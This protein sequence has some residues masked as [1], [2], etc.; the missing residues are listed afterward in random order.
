VPKGYVIVTE[1][2][3]DP[4]GM[5]A[6]GKLSGASVVE[7]GATVLVVDDNVEVVE[8]EWHG[9]RTIVLEYDSVEKARQW[10]ESASY[11]AA[12]PLRQAAAEC[13]VVILSGFAPRTE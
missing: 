3:H 13:N 7:Y 8:G 1:A 9:S 6:Y 10:Y 11:Q 2:I 4:A 5:E 12:A